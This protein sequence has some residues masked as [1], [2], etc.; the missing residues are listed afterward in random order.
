[1]SLI[2]FSAVAIFYALVLLVGFS[3]CPVFDPRDYTRRCVGIFL[4]RT[5][6]WFRSPRSR[7]WAAKAVVSPVS[8][9]S[10]Q[11]GIASLSWLQ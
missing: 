11:L 6:H 10:H 9:F 1:M 3:S 4:Q 2:I 5:N 8:A 7:A